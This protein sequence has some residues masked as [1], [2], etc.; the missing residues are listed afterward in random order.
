MISSVSCSMLYIVLCLPQEIKYFKSKCL[1]FICL[2]LDWN[3][4]KNQTH[5]TQLQTSTFGIFGISTRILINVDW[6]ARVCS[7]ESLIP[8]SSFWKYNTQ[9]LA[10]TT[11]LLLHS[12]WLYAH[13]FLCESV[14]DVKQVIGMWLLHNK[15][16]Q[17]TKSVLS[18]PPASHPHPPSD[19]AAAVCVSICVTT[20]GLRWS[21]IRGLRLTQTFFSTT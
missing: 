12:V 3:I 19:T 10:V 11:N 17:S 8:D 18:P 15:P 7:R 2:S 6:T 9:A 20:H 16:K 21:R 4:R 13:A 14:R 5:F 1:F